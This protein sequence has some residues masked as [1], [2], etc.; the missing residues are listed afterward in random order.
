[1]VK[2]NLEGIKCFLV[3]SHKPWL[4]HHSQFVIELWVMQCSRSVTCDGIV[5]SGRRLS[6]HLHRVSVYTIYAYLWD[7]RVEVWFFMKERAPSARDFFYKIYPQK[8]VA[9]RLADIK[10][11]IKTFTPIASSATAPESLLAFLSVIT[12]YGR[13]KSSPGDDT[14]KSIGIR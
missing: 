1:M 2:I 8:L 14:R 4:I 10:T 11:K 13:F 12:K 3:G 6:L 9:I 5:I 7:G